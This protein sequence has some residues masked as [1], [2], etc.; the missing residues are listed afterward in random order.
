MHSHYDWEGR[1]DEE[2]IKD[3][4]PT[5]AAEFYLCG[6]TSFLN[7]VTETLTSLGIGDEQIHLEQF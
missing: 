3:T 1:I 4:L 2:L 7:T 6:P 5:E